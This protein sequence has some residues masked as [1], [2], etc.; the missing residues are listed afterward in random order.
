MIEY[1]IISIDISLLVPTPFYNNNNRVCL[2]LYS[3]NKM[4]IL[5]VEG[6]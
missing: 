6:I 4:C 1:V 2:Y 3:R 5:I